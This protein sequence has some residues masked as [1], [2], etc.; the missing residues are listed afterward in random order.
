ML[1][2]LPIQSVLLLPHPRG[3]DA[4]AMCAKHQ[5]LL[6]GCPGAHSHAPVHAHE[7]QVVYQPAEA[8]QLLQSLSQTGT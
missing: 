5:Q 3:R 6:A 2:P 8:V 4:A 7:R 1:V